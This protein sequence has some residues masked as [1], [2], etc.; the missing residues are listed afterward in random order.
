MKLPFI[1][2]YLILL[3]VHIYVGEQGFA[4]A[5]NLTKPLLL[6][7]IILFFLWQSRKTKHSKFKGLM[8]LGFNFSLIG[9]VLLIFQ[10]DD[11]TFFMAG[12]GS[13]L[14]A[15]LAYIWAFTKTYIDQEI[16][17]IKRQGWVMVLV[18]GYG[19]YFFNLLKDH[20][21]G[22]FGPVILYVAA[23]TLML[24]LALN[25]FE[26]VNTSSFLLVATGATL[27][28]VS[29]SILAWNKFM[30]PVPYGHL[31]IMATYGLAQLGIL[32][33]SNAQLEDQHQYRNSL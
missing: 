12:L 4:I 17:L 27:F 30:R 33:G 7:S 11:T 21:G 24:L 3:A 10:E 14:I 13:F 22:L 25:R 31:L 8:L 5:A 28:V 1:G 18:I 15:H 29:D 20:L 2:F 6:G 16:A 9:D 32:L 26:R 19:L 23:I